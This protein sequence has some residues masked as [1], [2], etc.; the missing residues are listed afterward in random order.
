MY[1]ISEWGKIACPW[2][3]TVFL[4]RIGFTIWD[5]LSFSQGDLLQNCSEQRSCTTCHV[6]LVHILSLIFGTPKV[7]F[8]PFLELLQKFHLDLCSP[9]YFNSTQVSCLWLISGRGW[10]PNFERSYLPEY[11]ESEADF[12][13]QCSSGFFLRPL[14][15]SASETSPISKYSDCTKT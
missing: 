7:R 14:Q 10:N 4:I 15:L 5:L 12:W 13:T 1:E 3:N 9:I 8:G 6:S 11:S 2:S